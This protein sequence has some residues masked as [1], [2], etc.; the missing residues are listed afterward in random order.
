[1][2]GS[3]QWL[4]LRNDRFDKLLSL[5]PDALVPGVSYAEILRQGVSED[6]V[7][8]GYDIDSWIA[9]RTE[10]HRNPPPPYLVER[11]AGRW[12]LITEQRTREGGVVGIRA[13][14]TELKRG[15]QCAEANELLLRELV[16]A[17]PATIHTKDAT[18]N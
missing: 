9:K 15:E 18:I 13:D 7:P 16:D 2:F 6:S 11:A 10:A 14:V 4:V 12:T 5:P 17:V 3:D 8:Q 1:M